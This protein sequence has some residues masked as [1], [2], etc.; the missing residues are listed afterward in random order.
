[1][2]GVGAAAGAVLGAIA[3]AV[4]GVTII[5]GILLGAACIAI[6]MG[7]KRMV[8]DKE[9]NSAPQ[10][11]PAQAPELSED[12]VGLLWETKNIQ[13]ISLFGDPTEVEVPHDIFG[14]S[15][16]LWNQMW[17]Q[18]GDHFVKCYDPKSNASVADDKKFLSQRLFGAEGTL[19]SQ[20]EKDERAQVFAYL[21]SLWAALQ[22]P[23][24]PQNKPKITLMEMGD[25][26]VI[27]RVVS[28]EAL[29][30]ALAEHDGHL[31]VM[32]KLQVGDYDGEEYTNRQTSIAYV[33]VSLDQ[34]REKHR[35]E[36]AQVCETAMMPNPVPA[37]ATAISAGG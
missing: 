36:K 19:L 20:V 23:A 27:K 2:A 4:I 14:R 12:Q 30:M 32:A 16:P 26:P 17:I 33:D 7:I 3:G 8:H 1:M 10:S 21:L 15:D 5:A 22:G 28:G 35:F 31:R 25:N 29:G 9:V 18:F 24:D 11:A 13:R 37:P 34:L 6:A